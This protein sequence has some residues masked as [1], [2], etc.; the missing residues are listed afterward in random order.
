MVVVGVDWAATQHAAR[1]MDAAGTVTRR[2][3][4][5]HTAAGL[6]RLETAITSVEPTAR[7]V[8]AAIK[9]PDGLLGRR[10][11]G[12]GLR[13]VCAQSEEGRAVP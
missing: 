5:P 10:T 13:R 2:L 8:L 3:R 12:S 4:A 7:A 11:P 1:L 9:R 6:A